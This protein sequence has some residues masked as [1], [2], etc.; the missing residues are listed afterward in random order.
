MRQ[1]KG[2]NL[3]IESNFKDL[4]LFPTCGLQ[5]DPH[6]NR[7]TKKSDTHETEH[8]WIDDGNEESPIVSFLRWR[9]GIVLL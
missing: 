5:L 9:N 2:G 1:G 8:H 7:Q 4:V 3:Q 6:S